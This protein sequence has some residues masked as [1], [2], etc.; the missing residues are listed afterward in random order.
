MT[1]KTFAIAL[2]FLAALASCTTPEESQ[3]DNEKLN[4]AIEEVKSR[5]APDKRVA[6]FDI[7]TKV[8]G[9]ILILN[10]ETDKPA[11]KKELLAQLSALN[12]QLVDS[13]NTLPDAAL[14]ED[15]LGV[16]YLSAANMRSQPRHS[17]E[18]ATQATMGMPLR[19]LKKQGSWHLVQSPDK[20]ISWMQGSFVP[21]NKTEYDEWQ[22]KEK[23][24]FTEMYGFAYERPVKNTQTV[25]DLVAGNVME[26]VGETP[27]SYE[28]RLPD[29][30]EA[31]VRKNESEIFEDWVADAEA[32]ETTVVKTAMQLMGVPYLWGGTS[33]KGVD[34][35]GFTK[36]I[37]FMNGHIL[38]RDASQQV[39]AGEL[40]DEEKNYDKLRPGDLLFFGSAAT[41]S[42]RERVTHVGMWIGDGQF[43]HSTGSEARVRISSVD[44]ESEYYDPDN[45]ARYLRTKRMINSQQDIIALKDVELF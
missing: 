31:F 32:T 28:V 2:S 43:I 26:L 23:V 10:G 14:G 45:L 41:D 7:E 6:V 33:S 29:G 4:T 44:S 5:Y 9:D 16:V 25:A 30:R 24:I 21:M 37:Y 39:F 40:I 36:T 19:V 42:T 22:N 11:A 13:I 8:K 17:A 15:T 12:Y 38:P 35:S 20:Y 1:N 27:F 3:P 34:C 18:L